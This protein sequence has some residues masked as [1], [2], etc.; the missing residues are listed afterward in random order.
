MSCTKKGE[1]NP[2]EQLRDFS[3]TACSW[4]TSTGMSRIVT[5]LSCFMHSP[6]TFHL[7]YPWLHGWIFLTPSLMWKNSCNTHLLSLPRFLFGMIG[8]YSFCVLLKNHFHVSIYGCIGSLQFGAV[9]NNTNTN[10]ITVYITIDV[11]LVM[12]DFFKVTT[13]WFIWYFFFSTKYLPTLV[14]YLLC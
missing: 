4:V 5:S 3:Y 12:F 1:F 9:M 7:H 2:W 10:T 8:E 13:A 6:L 14:N 11:M